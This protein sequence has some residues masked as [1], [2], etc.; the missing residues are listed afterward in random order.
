[1][2]EQTPET[3]TTNVEVETP[4]TE[5][6]NVEVVADQAVVNTAPDG[7]GNDGAVENAE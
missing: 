1:M 7:G 6:Q 3:T 5:T 2:S 4:A